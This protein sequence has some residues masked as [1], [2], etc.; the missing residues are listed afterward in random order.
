MKRDKR[1][2]FLTLGEKRVTSA[3]NAL[4]L[5]GNL[6]DKNNYTYDQHDVYEIV[7][8]LKSE[9]NSVIERFDT[10]TKRESSSNFK[11]S[12]KSQ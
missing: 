10:A 5:V 9:L 11:F 4:R 1:E 7:K 8:A 12:K 2:R 3:V 6:T